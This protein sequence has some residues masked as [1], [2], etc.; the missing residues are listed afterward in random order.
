MMLRASSAVAVAAYHQESERRPSLL[1]LW[2]AA[3]VCGEWKVL[4]KAAEGGRHGEEGGG[5]GAEWS[6]G[7]GGE[8]REMMRA[9]SVLGSAA[10]NEQPSRFEWS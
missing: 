1:E 5:E 2:Q 6:G 8:R 7:G 4:Q 3:S 10:A 9:R